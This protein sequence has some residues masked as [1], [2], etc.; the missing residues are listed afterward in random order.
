MRADALLVLRLEMAEG[1]H[2]AGE[3]A[4]AHV[5]GGG[6]KAGDIPLRFRIPVE[7]LEPKR[8]RLSV[9]AVSAPNS[10][11]VLELE[12]ALFQDR[13]KFFELRRD[14]RGGGFDLQRLRR[15][16]HIVRRQAIVQPARLGADL[17]SERGGKG[18]D[19]MFDLGLDLLN[20]LDVNLATFAN[21]FSGLSRNNAVFG[22]HIA[23]CALDR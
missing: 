5:F 1:T 23:G 11:R 14:D 6:V 18:E 8:C 16:H 10:R 7:Q 9:N 3:L 17:L 22:K 15:I 21:S 20:S 19:V 12:R 2:G 13:S 4:D